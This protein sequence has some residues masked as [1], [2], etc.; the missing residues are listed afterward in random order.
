M[1][2]N[3]QMQELYD[4]GA[5]H[6]DPS[7]GR[8]FVVDPLADQMRR[9]SPYNYAFDNPIYFI[10]PDGMAPDDFWELNINTGELTKVQEVSDDLMNFDVITTSDGSEDLIVDKGILNDNISDDNGTKLEVDNDNTGG[11]LFEFLASNSSVEWSN[12]KLENNITSEKNVITSSHEKGTDTNSSNVLEKARVSGET[13]RGHDHSHPQNTRNASDGVDVN[14]NPA[15][16]IPMK[17]WILEY[18]NTSNPVFRIFIPN[19][20]DYINY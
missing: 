9:H 3:Y 2:V 11:E 18:N 7:L 10:D 1:R 15:G 6:Y 5:R 13:V 20:K 8:W 12:I 4:Y 14:G 16:D 17:N 19:T